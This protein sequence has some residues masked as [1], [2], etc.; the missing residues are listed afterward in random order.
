[1]TKKIPAIF[2]NT[3]KKLYITANY[4]YLIGFFF[5]QKKE[6]VT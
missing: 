1:M 4:S 2:F 5:K 3:L 6:A